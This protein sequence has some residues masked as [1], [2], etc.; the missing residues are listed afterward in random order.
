VGKVYYEDNR[1]ITIKNCYA[2][3]DV[4]STVT[5][6]PGNV[7]AAG[8]LIGVIEDRGGTAVIQNCA[9]LN[10][11]VTC[12]N[13][14]GIG[15]VIGFS[16]PTS[17][18]SDNIAYSGMT[19]NSATVNSG[20]DDDHDK[21]NGASKTAAELKSPTTWE[22]LFGAANFGSGK[23]WKWVTGYPYPALQWQAAGSV[24]AIPALP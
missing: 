15:R 24:P 22:T 4:S 6:T 1:T 16:N 3:G 19:L 11:A 20:S 2:T 13:T 14:S 5:G 21:K 23:T 8:G 7:I 10:Q 9:A 17:A 18:L 12:S